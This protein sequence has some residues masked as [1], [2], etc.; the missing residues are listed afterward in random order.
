MVEPCKCLLFNSS[1]IGR[2]MLTVTTTSRLLLFFSKAHVH[3]WYLYSNFFPAF[4]AFI[5]TL[6]H[7]QFSE[8]LTSNKKLCFQKANWKSYAIQTRW[9]NN[10]WLAARPLMT[11]WWF[12]V[13]MVLNGLKI[14]SLDLEDLICDWRKKNIE[15]PMVIF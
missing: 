6:Q 2:I 11:V 9:Y 1:S 14:E 15:K 10:M 13:V 4:F 12:K 7:T 8:K 5:F 3:W